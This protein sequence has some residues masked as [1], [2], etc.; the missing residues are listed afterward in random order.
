MNEEISKICRICLAE[1]SQNIF[2]NNRRNV[3]TISSLDRILEKLRFVTMLK[4]NILMCVIFEDDVWVVNKI[5]QHLRL[6]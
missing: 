5:G 4:V 6:R 2:H 3:D 1:G